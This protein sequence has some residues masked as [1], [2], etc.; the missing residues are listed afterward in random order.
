MDLAHLFHITTSEVVVCGD[1]EHRLA[2]ERVD[3]A[4]KR[5]DEGLTLTGVHFGQATIVQDETT[6][7]L[8][9]VMALLKDAPCSLPHDG[10]ALLQYL[11]IDVFPLGQPLPELLGLGRQLVVAE[12]L[13]VGLQGVDAVDALLQPGDVLAV[14][15]Q[16]TFQV[17]FGDEITDKVHLKGRRCANAGS[18]RGKQLVI[19]G[20][21]NNEGTGRGGW[22]DAV[23]SA[24]Q[25]GR[26]EGM[27]ECRARRQNKDGEGRRPSKGRPWGRRC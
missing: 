19:H 16:P 24:E 13:D 10:E 2:G 8:D 21:R 9:I 23:G 15:L 17:L 12:V 26:R 3:V 5:R 20:G 18:G 4:G 1:N 25:S 22:Y 27:A 6:K 11:A 14:V 7:K